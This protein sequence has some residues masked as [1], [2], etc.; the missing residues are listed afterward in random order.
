MREREKNINSWNL[1]H[2][3]LLLYN[4]PASNLE[5]AKQTGTSI[6][7]LSLRSISTSFFPCVKRRVLLNEAVIEW[8]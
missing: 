8:Q 2:T 3:L 6:R 4:I 1:N 7:S 5:I